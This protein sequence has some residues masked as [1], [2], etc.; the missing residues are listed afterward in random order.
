MLEASQRLHV[1]IAN[2][3]AERLETITNLLTP[4]P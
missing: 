1:L 2:E 4:R 3:R